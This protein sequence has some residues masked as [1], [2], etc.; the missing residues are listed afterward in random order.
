[1]NIPYLF[2]FFPYSKGSP[3]SICEL[4]MR[5]P[6]PALLAPPQGTALD[7]ELCDG[8]TCLNVSALKYLTMWFVNGSNTHNIYYYIC[9][10]LHKI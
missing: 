4:Q 10:T 6:E 2:L 3:R 8:A 9:Y 1:M 5:S 7:N